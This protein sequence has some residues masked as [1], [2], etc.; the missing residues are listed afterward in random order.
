[1][2]T[3]KK[4]IQT[5]RL[6][7]DSIRDTDRDALIALLRD[8]T[9]K[10]TYMLPDFANDAEAEPLFDRLKALSEN[11]DRFVFGIYLEN[12]LIGI[13]NDTEI[14]GDTVEMGYALLP[15]YYNRGYATEA[16]AA[17]IGHL[18]S[19]GLATVLAGAF[20]ENT[21]SIRV[22]EKCG[23]TRIDRTESIDYR[24]VTHLCVYYAISSC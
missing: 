1:M 16:F 3:S 8:E 15:A 12:T 11:P 5:A 13:L 2:K 17:V 22:M 19:K 9:V 6:T 23:M 7:L 18:F 14:Q 20:S 10:Q 4:G 21:A 24:G